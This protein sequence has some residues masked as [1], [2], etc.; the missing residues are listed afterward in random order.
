MKSVIF[1]GDCVG[2][3]A[4]L[5]KLEESGALNEWLKEHNYD[6]VVIGGGS[7]GLA[8]AKVFNYSFP[9]KSA[10]T[11]IPHCLAIVIWYCTTWEVF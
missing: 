6:L 11:C 10:P 9:S 2:G 4:D 7:G 5:L 8:A 3:L 1:Q